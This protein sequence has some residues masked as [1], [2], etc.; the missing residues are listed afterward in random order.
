MSRFLLKT[1]TMLIV[2]S[3]ASIGVA[4]EAERSVFDEDVIQPQL[5]PQGTTQPAATYAPASEQVSPDAIERYRQNYIWFEDWVAVNAQT[6]AFI[7]SWSV[8]Y[9]GKYKEPLKGEKFYEYAGRPDLAEQYRQKNRKKKTMLFTGLGISAV[10][11]TLTFIGMGITAK[12]RSEHELVSEFDFETECD[13]DGYSY[14]EERQCRRDAADAAQAAED[15]KEEDGEKKGLIFMATGGLMVAA[16]LTL[17]VIGLAKKAHPVRPEEARRIAD[18]YNTNLKREL[19]IP[20][21]MEISAAQK[22]IA[23]TRGA[24][25][26][27]SPVLGGFVNGGVLQ[28]VF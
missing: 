14:D 9:M 5:Q 18:D 28:V 2:L 11:A 21:S 10:G 24:K 19:G 23:N 4:Q 8:P 15:Q 25:L 17:S 6:G 22:S 3:L 7:S 16:G 12:A 26:S 1:L 27:L 20:L 13:I